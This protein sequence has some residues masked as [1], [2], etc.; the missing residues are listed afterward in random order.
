MVTKPSTLTAGQNFVGLYDSS[1]TRVAVSA[2]LASDWAV[3][4]YKT[5]AFTASASLTTG[6]YFA[7]WLSVGTTPIT[8]ARASAMN[9]AALNAGMTAAAARYSTGGTGWTAQTS[10]PSPGTMAN[11]TAGATSIW[12]ALS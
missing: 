6:A 1:G 8:V 7:A 10:L 9:S 5:T 3:S 2:D 12:C 4:G 11:R